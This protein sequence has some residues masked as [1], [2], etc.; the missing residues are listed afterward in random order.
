[1]STLMPTVTSKIDMEGYKLV[2]FTT[3]VV[4]ALTYQPRQSTYRETFTEVCDTTGKCEFKKYKVHNRNS[5]KTSV[6]QTFYNFRDTK[7]ETQSSWTL[8]DIL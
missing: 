8:I 6:E 1:M 2:I 7:M 3:L 5:H 4:L